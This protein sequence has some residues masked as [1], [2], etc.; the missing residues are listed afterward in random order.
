[1]EVVRVRKCERACKAG[2]R[3]DVTVINPGIHLLKA[4]Q[5]HQR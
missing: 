2:R 3:R 5:V 4:Y 1:M